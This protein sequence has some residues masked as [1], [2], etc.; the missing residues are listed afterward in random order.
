MQCENVRGR[1]YCEELRVSGRVILK[2]FK[3]EKDV[4][5][6]IIYSCMT[7]GSNGEFK[8]KM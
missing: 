1:I 3:K 5:V 4:S 6:L 8:L 2:R 7:R